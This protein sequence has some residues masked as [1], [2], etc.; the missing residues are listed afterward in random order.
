MLYGK[1]A[2]SFGASGVVNDLEAFNG[3]LMSLGTP[4]YPVIGELNT[5]FQSNSLTSSLRQPVRFVHTT[6]NTV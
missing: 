2:Y 4:V 6:P 5:M 1:E 3:E